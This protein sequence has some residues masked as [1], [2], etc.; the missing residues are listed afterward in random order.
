MLCI[1]PAFSL[2][3]CGIIL[4]T[5]CESEIKE[6][7]MSKKSK[8]NERDTLTGRYVKRSTEKKKPAC[9]VTEKRNK[10]GK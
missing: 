3:L 4:F 9:T 5:K 2:A 7:R 6:I 8:R 1:V 10:K